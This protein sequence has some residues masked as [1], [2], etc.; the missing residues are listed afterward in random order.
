MYAPGDRR[1]KVLVGPFEGAKAPLPAIALAAED[2]V[3]SALAPLGAAQ[4]IIGP[5]VRRTAFPDWRANPGLHM[6]IR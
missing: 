4:T 5:Q 1:V 2:S 6:T 3:A